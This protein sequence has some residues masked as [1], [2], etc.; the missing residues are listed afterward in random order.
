MTKTIL[1]LEQALTLPYC[2]QRFAQLGWRVIRIESPPDPQT[3]RGGDP[4]RYIGEDTGFDDLHSYY[5]PP[6]IG[7]EGITLNLKMKEGQDTLKRLVKELKVDVFLCN[8]LPMRYQQLGIDYNTLSQANPDVIWCGISAYGPDHPSMA[9]YDP[10]LQASLGYMYM[11]GEPD[12]DPMLCGLPIV[13]LKAGDEAFIQVLLAIYEQQAQ[14]GIGG[15]EIFISMAQAAASWLITVLPQLQFVKDESRLY[16]RSGNEHRS[17]IPCNCYPTKDG[18]V[19]L[20][21]GND[22][23][24]QKL[25]QITGFEHLEKAERKTNQGRMDD[26]ENIY[27]GIKKGL[28]NYTTSEF[29]EICRS[30]NLAVASVNSIKDVAELDFVKNNM[31]KTTLPSSETAYLFPAPYNTDFLTDKDHLMKCAPRLGEHNEK[32]YSEAGFTLQ[33]I[34]ELRENN[35]I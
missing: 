34:N 30:Q 25:T 2:T 11:T 21:I 7:K 12:R 31:L 28:E 1:S 24:W 33:E 20:A 17:F 16:T 19:Y 8:T 3:G 10:A 22:I 6:N 13:D 27:A 26:K 18:F 15:K 23:Q 29:I 4:N 14:N 32:V 5:I 35:I 9:G